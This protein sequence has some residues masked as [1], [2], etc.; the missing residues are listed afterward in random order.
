MFRIPVS[1]RVFHREPS[2]KR[3][4]KPRMEMRPAETVRS[5]ATRYFGNAWL[6]PRWPV[7]LHE[8][9]RDGIV[10]AVAYEAVRRA[11]KSTPLFP[12]YD[13]VRRSYCGMVMGHA[14]PYVV[15]ECVYRRMCDQVATYRRER[16]R[17]KEP[18]TREGLNK[19]ADAILS[20]IEQEIIRLAHDGRTLNRDHPRGYVY[21][22]AHTK[23][24]RQECYFTLGKLTR[25]K[26]RPILCLQT[27]RDFDRKNE[28]KL[29]RREY[30]NVPPSRYR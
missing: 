7:H 2:Q 22:R 11:P 3:L 18:L 10:R 29:R 28:R 12:L 21:V 25:T 6:P 23:E 15:G 14:G 26:E 24:R 1:H 9:P 30:R 8:V 13:R 4:F 20:E 17:L 27:T 16:W 19:V 5:W